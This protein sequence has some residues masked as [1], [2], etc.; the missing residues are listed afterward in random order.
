MNTVHRGHPMI[1]QTEALGFQ[2]KVSLRETDS[3][4]YVLYVSG[5]LGFFLHLLCA[6]PVAFPIP[7]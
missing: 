6:C 1:V 4:R 7:S 2:R 3:S 5:H